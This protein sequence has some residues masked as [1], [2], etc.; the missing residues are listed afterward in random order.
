M[1]YFLRI[2]DER[3]TAGVVFVIFLGFLF[4]VFLVASLLLRPGCILEWHRC[5]LRVKCQ[6]RDFPLQIL[7]QRTLQN[8]RLWLCLLLFGTS[9]SLPILAQT[10]QSAVDMEPSVR[11]AIETTAKRYFE[12]SA[13]GDAASLKQNSISTVAADFS[14][15][16]TAL[17]ENQTA[18][19]GAKATLRPPF[20]L[21]ADGP[22]PLAGAEFLCGV[23]GK[24]GQTKDSAEF[25]L[26]SLPP[27]KYAVAILDVNGSNNS[28][29]DPRT[30]TLVLQQSGTLWKLAGFFPKATQAAGHDAAWF[31]QH[32]R[33]FKAKS[34]NHNAWLY[35]GQAI[36]LS[37][38][39]DFVR[40]LDTD[41]LYD[42]SQGAQPSDVPA[43]G[44]TVDLNVGGKI[45]H[46]T[47]IFPLAVGNDLEVVVKY[48]AADISNTTR[49]FQEN[50]AVIKALVAKYPEL[51]DAFTGV[52]ARAVDP[53]GRDYGTLL[54][55]KDI[56]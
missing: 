53:S 18:F 1:P 47:D 23:F 31:T 11:T 10:C 12:M 39:V 20:L 44:N 26:S 8:R 50:T 28:K 22:S 43:N 37:A 3:F 29:A 9:L 55:M 49:T 33:N 41:R 54:A 14:A 34:Q 17:K 13:N 24:E 56:K 6:R 38:P 4:L 5:R 7:S 27:G 35:F 40:T 25:V 19:A 42:E 2:Y 48:Q 30:L 21:I 46:L 36:G 45:Y 52:V 32:A 15:I 51:R 16:E